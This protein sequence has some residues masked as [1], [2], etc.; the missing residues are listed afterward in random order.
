MLGAESYKPYYI[1]AEPHK[2]YH[3][4]AGPY[5]P[6]YIATKPLGLI[7]QWEVMGSVP[8]YTISKTSKKKIIFYQAKYQ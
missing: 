2:P 4:A 8:I 1:T 6:Y 5:K 3:I 7:G